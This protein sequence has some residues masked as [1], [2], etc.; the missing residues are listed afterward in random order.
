MT[1]P[2]NKTVK[3]GEP[4]QYAEYDTHGFPSQSKQ[5]DRTPPPNPRK[6]QEQTS[7]QDQPRDGEDE[8]GE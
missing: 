6:D 5:G 8:E 4:D 1:Y 2:D 7:E 3:P